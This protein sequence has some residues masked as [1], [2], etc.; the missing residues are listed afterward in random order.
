MTK[1]IPPTTEY[2][3]V[4]TRKFDIIEILSALV[5]ILIVIAVVHP[6]LSEDKVVPY[7]YPQGL[8]LRENEESF[9]EGVNQGRIEIIT[10][11]VICRQ[12]PLQGTEIEL[13]CKT[14]K[15][16]EELLRFIQPKSDIK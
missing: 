7:K 13:K 14:R 8:E 12:I 4:K 2:N 15:E 3:T 1:T 9:Q 11:Q 5:I 10:G 16:I 6:F